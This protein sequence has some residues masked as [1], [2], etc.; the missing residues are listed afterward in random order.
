MVKNMTI[1]DF[2]KEEEYI[3]HR[4]LNL[5]L[6][7]ATRKVLKSLPEEN[8]DR[9]VE[10]LKSLYRVAQT[11]EEGKGYMIPVLGVIAMVMADVSLHHDINYN[12]DFGK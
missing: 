11:D 12:M 5:K 7:K 8:M 4:L 3:I 6:N 1:E 2:T 10:N 9:I